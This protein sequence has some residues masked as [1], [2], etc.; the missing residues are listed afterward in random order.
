MP[1]HVTTICTVTGPQA[2]VEAFFACHIRPRT[3]KDGAFFDFQTIIPKPPIVDETESGSDATVGMMALVGDTVWTNFEHF[4]W[5]PR[6]LLAGPSGDHPRR[7]R[8]WLEK[9]RPAALEKAR[10]CFQCL[11][12]TGY[13]NWHEWSIANWG[14]KWNAYDYGLVTPPTDG[15]MVFKFDTA[16]SFP[17]PIFRRLA[18]L[19]PNLVFAV[20]SYD[21][22]GNFGCDGEFNGKNNYRCEHSLA[23]DE[24][25]ERVYGRKRDDDDDDD[26]M[27]HS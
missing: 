20:I 7:V 13:S 18:E 16:W 1:N 25:Y 22:G 10:K 27:V 11:A 24:M 4:T 19:R 26:E 21:E 3:D 14:T 12:E 6:D 23:T 8:A 5:V 9:T 2:E 15:R 17:E